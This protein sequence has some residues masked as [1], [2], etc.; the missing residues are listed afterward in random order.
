MD[1]AGHQTGRKTVKNVVT[2][3]EHDFAHGGIVRQHANNEL[4]VEQISDIG[5]WPE[6]E[7]LK[8]ADPIPVS[9]IGEHPSPRCR[10]IRR[11]CRSHVTETDKADFARDR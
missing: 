9:D 1:R 3:T 5:R 6:T 8:L 7:C 4:T 2:A 11:H 10:E